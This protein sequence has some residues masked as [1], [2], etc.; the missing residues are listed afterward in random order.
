MIR[1]FKNLFN[2]NTIVDELTESKKVLK[3]VAELQQL[4]QKFNEITTK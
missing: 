3:V 1:F 2:L 4:T